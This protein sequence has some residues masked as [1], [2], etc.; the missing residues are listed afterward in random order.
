MEMTVING[1]KLVCEWCQK[2]SN[3][4]CDE[5]NP[6]KEGMP[7]PKIYDVEKSTYYTP[8]YKDNPDFALVKEW[9]QKSLTKETPIY[10]KGFLGRKKL[11]YIDYKYKYIFFCGEKHLNEW[12]KIKD[13]KCDN[14]GWS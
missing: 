14:E 3:L 11:D 7:G 8:E 1:Y 12:Q 4:I 6:E 10:T 13:I 9:K 5:N 2:E